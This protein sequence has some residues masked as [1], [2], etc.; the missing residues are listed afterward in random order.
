MDTVMQFAET[1]EGYEKLAQEI[2][3]NIIALEG[4]E[5]IDVKHNVKIKGKSGINHQ[6]DVYWEYKYAGVSHKTLIECK[7][8]TTPVSLLHAR[9]MLG[10]ITDVPNSQG[11]LVTTQGYQAGV[12]D[13]CSH[14]GINLKIIRPP[15]GSDWDGCI[16]IGNINGTLYQNIFLDI[17]FEVDDKD[18]DTL[19][20]LGSQRDLVFYPSEIFIQE[21][22]SPPVLI[23]NWLDKHIITDINSA[24][25][26]KETK[27]SGL[28]RVSQHPKLIFG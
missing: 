28:F 9:N 3:Y 26:E 8:Y 1:S 21:E 25:I 4:I 15:I 18:Q 6:I 24:E 22:N 23:G 11:I 14:Y 13:F 20:N 12:T 2:Y 10:L 17:K 16:Q 19:I 5:N 27:I 7:Y